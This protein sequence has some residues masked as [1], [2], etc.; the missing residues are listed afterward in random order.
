MQ[1]FELF[2]KTLE[3]DIHMF[4][5]HPLAALKETIEE[6]NVQ[7]DELKETLSNMRENPE[8][9][10]DPLTLFEVKLKQLKKMYKA[11]EQIYEFH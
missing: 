3:R 1:Q 2:E 9:Y 11:D 6:T 8:V 7:R 10:Q 4:F 5:V